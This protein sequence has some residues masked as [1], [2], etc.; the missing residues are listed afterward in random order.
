MPPATVRSRCHFSNNRQCLMQFC[1]RDRNTEPNLEH[2]R[3]SVMLT[4]KQM[5]IVSVWNRAH[6]FPNTTSYLGTIQ[7]M[8]IGGRCMQNIGN[9]RPRIFTIVYTIIAYQTHRSI[10][11]SNCDESC[12]SKLTVLPDC[13]TLNTIQSAGSFNAMFKDAFVR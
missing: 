12:D 2:H 5:E 10:G 8:Y 6:T 1:S 9:R 13:C 4:G 7:C 11:N 3:W